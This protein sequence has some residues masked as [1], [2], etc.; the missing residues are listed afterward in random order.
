MLSDRA[1]SGSPHQN[2]DVHHSWERSTMRTR[3]I[4]RPEELHN[5]QDAS[6]GRVGAGPSG[7]ATRYL[8]RHRSSLLS[9][10]HHAVAVFRL[11]PKAL[12]TTSVDMGI[13][14]P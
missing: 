8:L 4:D 14:I 9:E 3:S 5:L 6:D 13:I 11:C 2:A 7:I 12:Y 10:E 1:G